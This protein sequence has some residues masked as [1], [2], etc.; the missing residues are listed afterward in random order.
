MNPTIASPQKSRQKTTATPA[1][2]AAKAKS[3]PASTNSEQTTLAKRMPDFVH[4]ETKRII[5]IAHVD[6]GWGNAIY[7]RGDGGGLSWDVGVP[8]V[9]VADD[10]WVWSYSE[11]QAPREFKFLRNDRDWALGENH[12]IL[13]E[14][15]LGF[16]PKFP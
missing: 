5:I 8:M 15:V 13:H 1:K 2:A 6:L 7:V 16:A 10:K 4:P 12:V 3:A 14:E 9:C 11:N